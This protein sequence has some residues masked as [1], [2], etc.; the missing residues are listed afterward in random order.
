MS[1]WSEVTP[2]EVFCASVEFVND[3]SVAHAIAA[4]MSDVLDVR[5]MPPTVESTSVLWSLQNQPPQ[6][7][8]PVVLR[9]TAADRVIVTG[10]EQNIALHHPLPP[11]LSFIVVCRTCESVIVTALLQ[12]KPQPPSVVVHDDPSMLDPVMVMVSEQNITEQPPTD[13]N[14]VFVI[15]EFVIV[16][17]RLQNIAEQLSPES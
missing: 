7:S 9:P 5:S 11:A 4:Q 2:V 16:T 13:V 6:Y 17:S 14:I 3:R 10:P 8:E 12:K 15:V 1:N